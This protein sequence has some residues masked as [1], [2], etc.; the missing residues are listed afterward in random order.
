MKMNKDDLRKIVT[1][2]CVLIAVGGISR[3]VYSLLAIA[4][5]SIVGMVI[6]GTVLS[7]VLGQVLA[8][9]TERVVAMYWH[10][11]LA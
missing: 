8:F 4:G 7:V 2:I 1:W 10:Q 6:F 11:I 9:A 3:I 5:C